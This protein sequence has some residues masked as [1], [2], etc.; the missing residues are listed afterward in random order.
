MFSPQNA[1]R[2]SLPALRYQ[3]GSKGQAEGLKHHSPG[4]RPGSAGAKGVVIPFPCQA[5]KG[6]DRCFAP[7]GLRS[8]LRSSP[9]GAAPQAE[10]SQ[11]F[12]LS[13]PYLERGTLPMRKET[14]VP[15]PKLARHSLRRRRVQGQQNT[16]RSPFDFPGA[17]GS[18]RASL[19]FGRVAAGD[20]TWRDD[21]RRCPPAF[22]H[23]DPPLAG[24]FRD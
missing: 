23:S 22:R 18:L 9:P 13:C 10:P 11:A 2:L 8:F 12:G 3:R 21:T 24:K 15:S 7:T 17:P 4:Q 5:L 16:A 14:V 1:Q 20:S 6:R 19:D